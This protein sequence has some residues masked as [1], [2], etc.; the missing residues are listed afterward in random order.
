MLKISKKK[1][2]PIRITHDAHYRTNSELGDELE[3][4]IGRHHN[5]PVV[6]A[7]VHEVELHILFTVN[8]K[9]E[10]PGLLFF[11]LLF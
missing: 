3:N 6:G 8:P 1:K 5:A 2:F 7:T 11:N 10:T 4:A 9:I